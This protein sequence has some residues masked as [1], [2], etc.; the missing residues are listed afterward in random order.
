[1]LLN[2]VL[3]RVHRH[4]GNSRLWFL[5]ILDGLVSDEFCADVFGCYM[6]TSGLLAKLLISSLPL[7]KPTL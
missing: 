7:I 3:G 5:L 2:F 6:V 4:S 1:M